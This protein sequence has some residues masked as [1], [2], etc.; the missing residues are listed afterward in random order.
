MKGKAKPHRKPEKTMIPKLGP[1]TDFSLSRRQFLTWSAT[2]GAGVALAGRAWGWSDAEIGLGVVGLGERGRRAVERIA[3]TPG[4][5]IRGLCDRRTGALRRAAGAAGGDLIGETQIHHLLADPRIDA[6]VVTVPPTAMAEVVA[7]AR[8]AKKPLLLARPVP[9]LGALPMPE[10]PPNVELVPGLHFSLGRIVRAPTTADSIAA[11]PIAVRFELVA[12]SMPELASAAVEALELAWSLLGGPR[13]GPEPAEL[14][15]YGG[16]IGVRLDG[17]RGRSL[18]G[19]L[20]FVGGDGRS[21]RLDLRLDHRPGRPLHG[22][23]ALSSDIEQSV[24]S[25]DWVAALVPRHDGAPSSADLSAFAAGLDGPALGVDLRALA[26]S[27]RWWQ[28][29]R[30]SAGC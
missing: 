5:Q 26:T 28:R 30:T 14:R 7:V 9:D 20:R 2:L 23:L 27:Q 29:L 8:V 15:A 12:G 13:V 10:G 11:D 24:G 3:V 16:P 1:A 18:R 21:R 25:A 6:L 17:T 22:R 19:S 4:V